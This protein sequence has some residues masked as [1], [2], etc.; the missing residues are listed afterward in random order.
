MVF[1]LVGTCALLLHTQAVAGLGCRA[2]DTRP[3]FFFYGCCR[4]R[5]AL[6]LQ[7]RDQNM[8]TFYP[9]AYGP[10]K[11]RRCASLVICALCHTCR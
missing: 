4:V 7:R 10:E 6:E 1:L 9:L 3:L 5:S 11:M 8:R 2:S